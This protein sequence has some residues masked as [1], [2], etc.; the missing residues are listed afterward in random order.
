SYAGLTNAVLR[1]LVRDNA[2][3]G[4]PEDNLPDWLRASWRAAYGAETTAAIAAALMREPTLDLTVRDD[5]TAVAASLGGTVL[6]AESVRV[7]LT[8]NIPDLPG[9]DDGAWWVQDAAAAL[10]VHLLGDLAGRRVID[11]CAA[12]GG[13]T[14]Q[15][16][17]SGAEVLA[18]DRAAKRLTRLRENLTR[19]GLSAATEV[20]DATTWR[21][22]APVDAVLLDAPC[23]ATGTIRR[24]PDILHLKAPGDIARLVDLQ[25]R[26]LANAAEM[27][28]PGGQLMYCT[29]SLQP[30][31]GEARVAAFLAERPDW[32]R[33][34]I[35][36][37]E[38]AGG[39]A[40]LTADGDL[41][42]LPSHLPDAGGLDGFYAARLTRRVAAMGGGAPLK[43]A[44]IPVND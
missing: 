30:E 35:A 26:L 42:T 41:R 9:Y 34:P 38:I 20:A 23:S 2:D 6:M 5:P 18:I 1:G 17:Q 21:P 12:P 33:A 40:W 36:A 37:G 24:H 16:C 8:G 14:A 15:L 10:P 29:C 7:P 28:K 22:K 13:K 44:R 11:L 39:G 19:L 31:E 25:T 4:A 32:R 3:L 27:V 43:R